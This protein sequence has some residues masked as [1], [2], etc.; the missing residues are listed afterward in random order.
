MAISPEIFSLSCS[1]GNDADNSQ[2][3][4][5][6]LCCSWCWFLHKNSS[7]GVFFKKKSGSLQTQL[8]DCI[9]SPRQWTASR[10]EKMDF[11][12]LSKIFHSWPVGKLPVLFG[13]ALV[14]ALSKLKSSWAWTFGDRM[15]FASL[16]DGMWECEW[17]GS[18]DC[19]KMCGSDPLRGHGHWQLHWMI[20]SIRIDAFQ[21]RSLNICTKKYHKL[22]MQFV[23]DNKYAHLTIFN[24]ASKW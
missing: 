16:A 23:P 2:F 5:Q 20:F 11:K 10:A 24:A 6:P 1:W 17:V 15:I 12:I 18:H 9:W 21:Y 3:T 7:S 22:W 13:L 4:Q 19:E 14:T 8:D